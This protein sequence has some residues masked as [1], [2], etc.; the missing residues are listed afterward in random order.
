MRLR[1]IFKHFTLYFGTIIFQKLKGYLLN[2][3]KISYMKKMPF[4]V[5]YKIDKK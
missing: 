4:L 5:F 3:N 2:K 1:V